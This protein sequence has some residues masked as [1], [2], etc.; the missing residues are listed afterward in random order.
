MLAVQIVFNMHEIWNIDATLHCHVTLYMKVVDAF[1]SLS[2]FTTTC[3][4]LS[5]LH[6]YP[7]I[8]I[9]Q[10]MHHA[11]SIIVEDTF[12][13]GVSVCNVYQITIDLSTGRP[14]CCNPYYRYYCDVIQ[15]NLWLIEYYCRVIDFFTT[16]VKSTLST[17]AI[18]IHM[19]Y[20]DCT[21][22]V[23]MLGIGSGWLINMLH[24]VLH[25]ILNE[26]Q[27]AYLRESHAVNNWV[28]L[29]LK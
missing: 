22:V 1:V 5:I 23:V 18:K 15:L 8:W 11:F 27:M 19:K 14:K 21:M 2:S 10:D 4:V 28:L 29:Y 3:R 26:M 20:I 24:T 6:W 25:W 13:M 7:T 16:I 9:R 12:G 17:F